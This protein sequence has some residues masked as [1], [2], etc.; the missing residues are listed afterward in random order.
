M[1]YIYGPVNS[2]RLG[3]SL[4]ISLAPYKICNFDCIYCQ[5]GKTTV[6]A[7]ARKEYADSAQILSELKSWLEHNRK[8]AENLNYITFSGL[9]EPTLHLRIGA[10][11][12][13][14]KKISGIPVAV[15]TNSSLLSHPLVRQE[16]L[17][18]DLIAPSLD[19]CAEKEFIRIDRPLEEIKLKEIIQGLIAFRKEFKGKIWLEVMLVAGINDD[20]RQIRKL[21]QVIEE[22]SP[23][24][25]H[26]NS[27]VRSTT[28]PGV[29]P[30]GRKK[31]EKIKE[32]LGENCEI[33]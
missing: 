12:A 18:A 27:P 22:I 30:V 7:S 20:L 3:L 8:T 14:V 23:D 17:A 24:K 15:I 19:A 32:I 29:L 2:R 9:G 6:K 31:L 33:I 11:I 16:L 1:K 5:L 25:I 26:L 13:E 4:G 21:K 28:E 10:L